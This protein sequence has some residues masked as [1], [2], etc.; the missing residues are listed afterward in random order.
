MP[1]NRPRLPVDRRPDRA[2]PISEW[3]AH[4]RRWGPSLLAW[5]AAN[6]AVAALAWFL[7][8]WIMT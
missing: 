5:A 1:G 3:L 6:I 8:G 4:L 7:V 2:D